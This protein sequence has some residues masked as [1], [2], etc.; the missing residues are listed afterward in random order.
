[1]KF[2]NLVDTLRFRAEQTPNAFAYSFLEDGETISK[3][4]TYH[5]L[6]IQAR[7]IGAT[8]QQMTPKGERALMLYPS[9]LDF[10]AAF[11]G[12][13][14]AGVV[15]VPALP[16]NLNRIQTTIDRLLGIIRDS[17]PA[18]ILTTSDLLLSLKTATQSFP[19]FEGMIWQSTD[20]LQVGRAFLWEEPEL[21]ASDLSFLQYTSGSTST[22]KGVMVSHGNTMY[23][24][25][26][27]VEACD[28]GEHYNFVSWLPLFH[29]LGLI[30]VVLNN[31]Y[32]GGEAR[33]MSP[34][35]FLKS[36]IRWLK[37]IAAHKNVVS[38]GPNFAWDLVLRKVKPEDLEGLDFSEWSC[39]FSGAETVR[40]GTIDKFYQLLKG[41]GLKR[42]VILPCYGLAEATLMVSARKPGKDY[43]TASVDKAELE[44][45]NVVDSEVE[46]DSIELVSCGNTKQEQ[47]IAIVDPE[48]GE[49][50]A[51]LAVGE[52]WLKGDHIA[53]GYWQNEEKTKET[54]Q[55]YTT[56]GEGP[57]LRTGDLGYLDEGELYIT[58]RIKEL[59]LMRGRCLYPQDLELMIDELQAAFPEIRPNGSVS[60][61]MTGQ[62]VE[63]IGL[64]VEVN[65]RRNPDYDPEKLIA[66]I[67]KHVLEQFEASFSEIALIKSSIPKTS[68]GKKMRNRC[69][70]IMEN[71]VEK[72]MKVEHH[73]WLG[74]GTNPN[75][76]KEV[77]GAGNGQS[78]T[79]PNEKN[80]EVTSKS[81]VRK[82]TGNDQDGAK[83]EVTNLM[84]KV[85][86][87]K[88]L[89]EWVAEEQ[90]LEASQISAVQPITDF[91]LDSLAAVTLVE[92]LEKRLDTAL[93]TNLVFEYETIS[94]LAD[95]LEKKQ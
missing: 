65:R 50:C 39:A 91:G 25:K 62:S 15:A 73:W 14:Y 8:L 66:A 12:C 9:G 47:V 67:Q 20:N 49:Q 60:F 38:G 83:E 11:M 34:M 78:K 81:F 3:Q 70:M 43:Q 77:S 71:G 13:Q 36:P 87:E 46:D 27:L 84:T 61:S 54:F 40:A 1:M 55:A 76:V 2:N 44:K 68:S 56:A 52:I 92:Y 93:D 86:L 90:K 74:S 28:S 72:E 79:N 75:G 29:D 58:G 19:E 7:V 10:V 85:E 16:P 64:I 5:G 82:I 24:M 32:V 94:E 33:L 95:F 63:R 89:I 69:R 42:E 30:G 88:L 80:D 35:S 41:H 23:N 31:L 37:A 4:F 45:G 53:L 21:K 18:I 6:D 17:Q 57:F 59:I 51:D 48:T 22:P 26:M